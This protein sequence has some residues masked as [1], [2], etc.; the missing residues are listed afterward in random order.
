MYTPTHDLLKDEAGSLRK[1]IAEDGFMLQ[2]CSSHEMDGLLSSS[3]PPMTMDWN[4]ES[5]LVPISVTL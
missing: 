1:R 4:L 2:Q 5:R 3:I